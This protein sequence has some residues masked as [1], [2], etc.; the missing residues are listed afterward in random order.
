MLAFLIL[1]IACLV[2]FIADTAFGTH[3]YALPSMTW[4]ATVKYGFGISNIAG[5][6]G[7]VV[8]ATWKSGRSY[9]RGVTENITNSHTTSQVAARNEV[10]KQSKIWN[11][12][13]NPTDRAGWETWALS[14]PRNFPNSGGVNELIK[15]NNGIMSGLNALILANGLLKS[16]GLAAK[17]TAPLAEVAPT[18]PTNVA[19]SCVAGTATITWVD[20][21]QC[22]ATAKMRLFARVEIPGG[23]VQ[24]KGAYAVA[25]QTGA[26]TDIRMGK[27][28]NQL[29]SSL[30]GKKLHVQMDCVNPGGTS[31]LPSNHAECEIA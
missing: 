24:I 28:V 16:C 30:V 19:V 7:N 6:I 1:A 5:K 13:L 26:L 4:N 8:F 29:L 22:E 20:P 12:T 2:A 14:K 23:F 31:S 21:V 15:G 3:F 18:V 17:Q 9:M 27:G 11:N 10:S 25:A